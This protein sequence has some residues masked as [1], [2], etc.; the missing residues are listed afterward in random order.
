M[1]VVARLGGLRTAR[2][3]HLADSTHA[4]TTEPDEP[5]LSR[6]ARLEQSPRRKQGSG[7]VREASRSAKG[8]RQGNGPHA[9]D[10][11]SVRTE[12]VSDTASNLRTALSLVET[13]PKRGNLEQVIRQSDQ[14]TEDLLFATIELAHVLVGLRARAE[15]ATVEATIANLAAIL[16]KRTDADYRPTED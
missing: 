12:Q 5:A 8:L 9:F 15:G 6:R 13:M 2:V 10:P 14:S 4:E 3:V 16:D 7:R 11:Q 1:G